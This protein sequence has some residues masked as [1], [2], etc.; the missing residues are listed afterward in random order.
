MVRSGSRSRLSAQVRLFLS[1]AVGALAIIPSLG[2]QSGVEWRAY[3]YNAEVVER[4]A[5]DRA[6]FV[7]FRHWAV[8]AC[9]RFEENVLLD[10]HVLSATRPYYCIVLAYNV[11]KHLADDWGVSEPPGVALLGPGGRLL[12]SGSGAMSKEQLLALFKRANDQMPAP[13]TKKSGSP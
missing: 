5:G 12:A 1:V 4:D 9:T 3:Q 10:P 2:C 11:D 6:R 13:T 7:Y 8:P